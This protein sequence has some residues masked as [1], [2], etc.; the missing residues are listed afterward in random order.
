MYRV[1]F[2]VVWCLLSLGALL[3]I[4]L[5]YTGI[6]LARV[7]RL[8]QAGIHCYLNGLCRADKWNRKR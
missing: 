5:S 3:G 1:R 4:V 6:A 8:F 2:I 7:S